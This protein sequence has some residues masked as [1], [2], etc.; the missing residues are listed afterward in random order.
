MGS[1]VTLTGFNNIDFGMILD[2]VMT[3]ESQPLTELETQQRTLQTRATTYRTLAARL[4]TF[5]S[6]VEA[7]AEPAS[8]GGRTAANTDPTLLTASASG[9]AAPGIYDVIVEELARTQVTASSNFPP[10]PDQTVVAWGG[11]LTIGG[12]AV[13][14]DAPLTL[15]G[16]ADKINAT[17]G[18]PVTATVIRASGTSWQLV[19]TG[20]TT[21]LAGGFT[22]QNGMTGGTG[23]T[24]TDTDGNGLS[25]DSAADNAVSATDARA[26]INNIPVTS[27][28]NT[29]SD[30]ILGVTLNLLKK[31]PGTSAT[32]SV[33]EDLTTTKSRIQKVVEAYNELVKFAEE[34]QVSAS[35]NDKASIARDPLLRGLRAALREHLGAEYAAGGNLKALSSIGIEFERTGRLSFDDATFDAMAADH[36][37]DLQSLFSAKGADEG[38]FVQLQ[39]L[40]KSYTASDGLLKDMQN[41]ITEQE[42][43]LSRRMGDLE[44]R[45]LQRRATLQQEFI[46]AD[47]AMS[48]M[49]S[50]VNS[51]SSLGGQYRLF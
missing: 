20:K 46:A 44:A 8:I 38:V 27:S 25:G 22:I 43:T 17:S 7:L 1:P 12:V 31:S 16:L 42:R 2:A 26:L 15:Q 11:A 10:D 37:D 30:A 33:T 4:S 34:Q 36:R 49:N 19:L 35:R 47:L 51:L 5:Q 21:G 18:S 24:F 39:A 23:M 32:V 9:S 6:A 14:I 40:V 45:L 28:T 29:I 3:Q 48:R 41:R 13:A 50:Q